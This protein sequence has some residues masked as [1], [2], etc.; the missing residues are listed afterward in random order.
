[1]NVELPPGFLASAPIIDAGHLQR[2]AGGGRRRAAAEALSALL[3]AL[4]PLLDNVHVT[5]TPLGTAI[6]RA[7]E[8]GRHDKVKPARDAVVKALALSRE[9][10]NFREKGPGGDDVSAWRNWCREELGEGIADVGEHVGG[11]VGARAGLKPGVTS[12]RRPRGHGAGTARR[13]LSEAFME[14][15]APREL[16]GDGDVVEVAVPKN[17]PPPL[18]AGE[19]S[20]M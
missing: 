11:G 9:L 20:A 6:E 18:L 8:D 2:A 4:G 5:L 14:A 12:P 16:T 17:P 3:Y 13:E 1:M 15:H 19:L 10:R 7:L